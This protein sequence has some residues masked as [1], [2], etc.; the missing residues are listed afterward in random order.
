MKLGRFLAVLPLMCSTLFAAAPRS[1]VSALNGVDTNPCTRPLPC[2]S[3]S[4]AITQTASTEDLFPLLLTP[5]VLLLFLE[6]LSR[7]LVIR[8]FP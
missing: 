3:F 1:F 5:A 8:R 7:V 2:R 6:A 4:T